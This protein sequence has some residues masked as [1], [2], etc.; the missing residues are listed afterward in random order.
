MLP[1]P[2]FTAE[3]ITTAR[4]ARYYVV[5]LLY[6]LILLLIV[7]I[8]YVDPP[9]GPRPRWGQEMTIQEMANFA[10]GM[11][12]TFSIVQCL[13]VLALTPPLFGGA[14]VDEKQRKTLHY[15]LASPLTSAEIVLGKLA[16]RMLHVGVFVSLG[17]PVMSL[18]SLF[19]GVDPGLVIASYSAALSTAFFLAG[20]SILVSTI[21]RRVREAIALIFVLELGWLLLPPLIDTLTS[22]QWP[23][24]YPWIRTVNDSVYATHPLV[25]L[26]RLSGRRGAIGL[27]P[28]YWLVGLQLLYG[29]LFVLLAVWRLR[30]IFKSQEGGAGQGRLARLNARLGRW[31]WRLWAKPD[32]G[33]DPMIWKELHSVRT[34][35]LMKVFVLLVG[36]SL[37]SFLVYGLISLGSRAFYEMLSWGYG[38]AW[39]DGARND[40]NAFL[41]Y[42]CTI[43][44]LIWILCVSAMAAGG[45]TTEREADTWVSL[46][47]TPLD[48]SEILRA[49]MIGAAWGV[50]LL[51]ALLIVLW[52][53]GLLC[54]SV[55]PAGF[56]IVLLEAAV[57]SWFAIALGTCA[58]LW[59]KSTLRAQAT[60]I[61]I[62]VVLN[63][64]YLLCCIPLSPSTMI[65]SFGCT[66][67]IEAIS[68]LSFE[69]VRGM[70][71][72][73]SQ[74]MS[75]R[76]ETE[77][78]ITCVMGTLAYAA[79]AFMLTMTAIGGFD[80]AVDRPRSP[81]GQPIVPDYAKPASKE[82]YELSDDEVG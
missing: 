76:F 57:F 1:G 78:I 73:S 41:R 75:R 33:D 53:L 47:G 36:L 58:S 28:V 62:L 65:V 29:S 80:R 56:L 15:L 8:N 46:I 68:L 51:G 45:V 3:L 50:R 64:G 71:T 7:W 14:I 10:D 43:V 32:C 18:L 52:T 77:A 42:V 9:M 5:R 24:L 54:G 59:S 69:D 79:G 60:T 48:G 63:G 61:A 21:T 27:E 39:K 34:S 67:F 12:S 38:S 30:P 20:L 2:V 35:G 22:W 40:F 6:G 11:F 82:E 49:K 13:M 31:R 44:Y 70:L 17:L 23:W 26:G 4:R 74:S 37:G 81:E 25:A 72:T 55:H 66:P 19:G 16:A